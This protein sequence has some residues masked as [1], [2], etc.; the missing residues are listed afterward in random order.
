MQLQFCGAARTVT[1]SCHLLTL[2]DG[3]RILLD[4]GLYQGNDEDMETFNKQWF[5]KPSEIDVLVLSHAHIDHSGRIPKLV[6]DGFKGKIYCTSATRDLCAIMLMDSAHIQESDAEHER[7]RRKN[8][9]QPLY[10][11][12]HVK[13]SLK[14]FRTVEYNTW[15]WIEKEVKVIFKDAGHILGSASVTLSIQREGQETLLGFTGDIGRYNR[16]ILKNPEPMPA[17]DYLITESTYGGINHDE[18]PEDIR[19]FM[20]IIKETCI[21]N[22][23][24]LIIPAFSIGRTQEILHRLNNLYNEGSLPDI[25]V[26]VDS[27]LAMNA[28]EIF[29][30]H[31]ECMDDEISKFLDQ[32]DNPFGWNHMHYIKNPHQ[33]KALNFSG[34]P[35]IIISASGMAEAG[36]IKHHLFHHISNASNTILIV[37]Y[38]AAGTLGEKLV[39][40]P[41][42]VKIF[43]EELTVRARIEVISSMSA[44]GDEPEMLQFH[45]AQDK[46]KLKKVF[47]VHGEPKRQEA[48]KNTLT[49]NGYK[50]IEIPAL[51]DVYEI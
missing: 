1:G 2:T 9:V 24:K 6:K 13:Q 12:Y 41:E 38:C 5:F 26:Y 34:E 32:D 17:C 47:L 49:K 51:G 33:S 11:E 3:T 46:N 25:P 36:R 50:N 45:E 35:C 39:R 8:N 48:F 22:R 10:T 23:G 20:L 15:F 40:K 7:K 44:H 27:P 37:G 31:P 14:L 18:G 42:T 30:I 4:C 29:R 28:T 21:N 19:K 16:P 43:G